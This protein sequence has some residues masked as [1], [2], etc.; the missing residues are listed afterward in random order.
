M[1]KNK[2]KHISFQEDTYVT[3]KWHNTILSRNAAGVH[4]GFKFDK[5]QKAVNIFCCTLV[6]TNIFDI[7][8]FFEAFSFCQF[9][10][11]DFV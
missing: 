4:Y 11:L 1:K 6:Y 2:E 9:V 5:R 10:E 8:Y 7:T 3:Q